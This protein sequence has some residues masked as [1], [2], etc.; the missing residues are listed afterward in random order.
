MVF[1]PLSGATRDPAQFE[2]ARHGALRSGAR[3]TTSRSGPGRTG[4]SAR[5]SPGV[6]CGWRSRNG[7][8]RIPDY[9]LTEGVEVTEHGGGLYS[10]DRLQLSWE[11]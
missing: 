2:D 5:T 10:I 7:T 9:R 8:A 1:V 3:T 11:V 6:S 4:A